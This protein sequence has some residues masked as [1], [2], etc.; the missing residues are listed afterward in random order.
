MTYKEKDLVE[1]SMQITRHRNP[2]IFYLKKSDFLI[3]SQ[4]NGT[5]YIRKACL[6]PFFRN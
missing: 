2:E 6:K 5:K 3:D 1:F 4:P